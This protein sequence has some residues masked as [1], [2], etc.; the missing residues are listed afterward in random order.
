MTSWR[1]LPDEDEVG[2]RERIHRHSGLMDM[3]D[4]ADQVAAIM[5]RVGA[6]QRPEVWAALLAESLWGRS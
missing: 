4:G 5:R 1:D 2:E 3:A 6:D